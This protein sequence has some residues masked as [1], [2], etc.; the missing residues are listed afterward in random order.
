MK[1][2]KEVGFRFVE[3]TSE[4]I[5]INVKYS[6]NALEKYSVLAEFPFDSTR[7][8]MSLIVL[9]HKSKKI[10]LM[11]KGAD[12]IMLPR[13][14]LAKSDLAVINKHLDEFACAGLRTLVMGQKE[15]EEFQFKGWFQ[16]YEQQMVSNDPLKEEKLN[17]LY[18][19]ME[20]GLDF[21][22]CSA[23]EDLL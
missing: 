14:K 19:D 15:L 13:T 7:K 22:G 10:Y 4:Y 2:A 3:K 18:D 6:G 11:T 5:G 8:R 21:V 9:E 16:R 17:K 12:S 20:N 23:I 1:G